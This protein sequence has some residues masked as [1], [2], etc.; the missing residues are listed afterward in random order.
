MVLVSTWKTTSYFI[1]KMEV[2]QKLTTMAWLKDQIGRKKGERC[3]RY[4]ARIY[5]RCEIIK[6]VEEKFKKG[7]VLCGLTIVDEEGVTEPDH[8]C[9]VYGKK[10]A[11]LNMMVMKLNKANDKLMCGISYHQYSRETR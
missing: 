2:M 7:D 10:K 8:V 5:F 11:P 1:R 4:I 9:C 6:E 3:S